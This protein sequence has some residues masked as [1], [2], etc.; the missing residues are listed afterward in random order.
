MAKSKLFNLKSV[1]MSSSQPLSSLLVG[2]GAM[3]SAILKGL[4]E[5]PTTAQY[6]F[7]IKTPRQESISPFEK[8]VRVHWVSPDT[9]QKQLPTVQLVLFAVKPAL[10]P[11]ILKEYQTLVSPQ[12]IFLS[13]AAGIPTQTLQQNLGAQ[14]KVC[15]LMPNLPVA[16]QK[17]LWG[18]YAGHTLTDEDCCKVTAFLKL[19]G[20]VAWIEEPLFDAFT[21]LA[22]S[23][24]AYV[25]LLL[26]ILEKLAHENGFS[27]DLARSIAQHMV[28]GALTHLEKAGLPPIALREQVTSPH[29]T[30]AAALNILNDASNGL[31][32]L[33]KKAIAA[34]SKRSHDMAQLYQTE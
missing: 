1:E 29:G 30:T 12:T 22:G 23:G 27:P 6:R 21:A 31:R 33:F 25:F 8:D 3:G 26:E 20:H 18:V 5:N 19:T 2:C 24:P 13:I 15:R 9:G 32:P 14:A 17:G 7:Y 4:L 28:S 16:Y 10:L 11:Q 34:A